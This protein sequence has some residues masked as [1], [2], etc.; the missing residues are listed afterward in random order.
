MSRLARSRP[1]LRLLLGILFIR[2]IEPATGGVV[3]EHGRVVGVSNGCPGGQGL[4]PNASN[5]RAAVPSAQFT[6]PDRELAAAVL[7]GEAR[8]E[9]R[10]GMEAVWEVVWNRAVRARTNA[11]ETGEAVRRV[12]LRPRQFSCLNGVAPEDLVAR[13]RTL[14]AWDTA[15]AI[16]SAPPKTRRTHGADHY[17]IVGLNPRWSRSHRPVAV[18]GRHKFY[19]I[20]KDRVR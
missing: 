2:A 8:G 14:W 5:L 20:T 3:T 9:G 19:R 16:A 11:A 13:M 4:H 12:L 1:L 6:T 17:E 7:C 15:L 18:V 10:A